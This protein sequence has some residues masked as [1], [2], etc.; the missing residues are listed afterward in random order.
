MPIITTCRCGREVRADDRLAGKLVRCPQCRQPLAIPNPVTAAEPVLEDAAPFPVNP[1]DAGLPPAPVALND[2]VTRGDARNVLVLGVARGSVECV[3]LGPDC[4]YALAAVGP[5]VFWIDLVSFR[6]YVP[7]QSHTDDVTAVATSPDGRHAASADRAGNVRLWDVRARQPLRWLPG[8]SGRV[9]GL[10]FAP[11]AAYLAS[12]GA[13][14]TLRLWEVATGAELVRFRDSEPFGSVAYSW[15]GEHLLTGNV[16]G[17]VNLWGVRQA[18]MIQALEGW[19]NDV[20]VAV[21]FAREGDRVHGAARNGGGL[22][23]CGWERSDRTDRTRYTRP[24]LIDGYY[25]GTA[26]PVK[27]GG[28]GSDPDPLRRA[29]HR[30]NAAAF[31]PWGKYCLVVGEPHK[32]F[33]YHEDTER[34]TAPVTEI[35]LTRGAVGNSFTFHSQ[36][37]PH[38]G[39]VPVPAALG[40]AMSVDGGHCLIGY[41]DASVGFK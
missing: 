1:Q 3:A 31:S 37:R 9:S 4:S 16:A 24:A 2:G 22:A 14:A 8:H 32:G 7:L 36:L 33:D 26:A 29:L 20:V 25:R 38:G 34:W 21:A 13:D 18:K 40:I 15:D 35:E 39:P 19:F 27:A 10:A 41:D 11:S 17:D 23:L 30:A 28:T 12:A 6:E 5:V